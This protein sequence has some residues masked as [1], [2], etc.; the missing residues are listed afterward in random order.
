MK[1]NAIICGKVVS[2]KDYYPKIIILTKKLNASDLSLF[3]KCKV[4][5]ILR[6]IGG[7]TLTEFKSNICVLK[8]NM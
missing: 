7:N 6:Y 5:P 8:F 2:K 4:A 1:K 3:I